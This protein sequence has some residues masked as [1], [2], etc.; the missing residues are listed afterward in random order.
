[1][2]DTLRLQI[3][4]YNCRGFNQTKTAYITSLLASSA[5]L[6]LQ[7]HWLSN[8]QLRLLGDIDDNFIY[9]GVSG[10]DNSDILPG[11]PYGGCAI[12]WKSDLDA[13]VD[14]LQTNSKRLC[15][16]RMIGDTFRLLFINCYMPYENE[17]DPSTTDDFVE[18]LCIIDDLVNSNCDCHI[19]V[20]GDLNVDLSRDRTH[21]LLLNSFCENLELRAVLG[22][23]RCTIDYSYNFNAERFSVLDHFLLSN[24]IFENFVEGACV[25]HDM[26]NTSDHDPIFIKL[27]LNVKFA[28]FNERNRSSRISWPKATESHI[29]DY[30]RALSRKLLDISL[31]VDALACHDLHCSQA[32]H[33]NALQ[34]Y[35]QSITNAC[36]TA[37]A[38]TI[39]RTCTRPNTGRIPGWSEHVR[40]LRER[41][42]F[43]HRMWLDCGRPR[44]GVVSESMR[45]TRA[46]Y[47]Y[48]LRRIRK[49]EEDIVR[50]RTADAMLLN[51]S[52]D[53]WLE[54]KRIR[55]NKACISR[56]IDG[57]TEDH[58][59]VRM[60]A[61]KYR[62]LFSRVPC[63]AEEMRAVENRVS[64]LLDEACF[65][66]NCVVT[67]E[68]V[69][70][71]V[72]RLKTHK[73][74][75]GSELMS[76]HI[77]NAG[78]DL[79][80][81]IACLL[82]T[83]I[84]HG[85]APTTF[86]IGTLVSIP[87]G[88][89]PNTSKSENFRGIA[90]SSILGKVFDN[91][92]LYR[93]QNQLASCDLQFGFKRHSSTNLCTMVLKETLSY[94][95][96]NQTPVFCTFLDASK[97]FDRIHYGK[98]FD[99]L[100][101]RN[102]P[103]CIIRVLIN[104]YTYNLL[105]VRWNGVNTDYFSAVNGVKQGAVL[106][107]VLFC[108][109]LDNLLIALSKAGVGC[110]IGTTFVGALAYADDIVIIA[111]TAT[112]MRKLLAICDGYAREYYMSFNAQKSKFMLL[113]PSR[114]RTLLA[115]YDRCVF[116]INNTPIERVHS[117]SH[118]GHVITSSLCDDDDIAKQRC[119]FIGQAN[120]CFCYFRKLNSSVQYNLFRTY[121]S[122]LYGCELWLLDNHHVEDICIAWRKGLRKIWNVSP[123]THSEL[124]SLI[125]NCL[126][127]LD[128]ICRRSLLFVY[129]CIT[130][131]SPLVGFIAQH[132]I[133]HARGHSFLGRNVSFCMQ[134]YKIPLCH[135]VDGSFVASIY[136][137]VQES[138]D[139]STVA[140]ANLLAEVL[141]LRDGSLILPHGQSSLT[142]DDI[143]D[144]I[145]YICIE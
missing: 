70:S 28:G 1:M 51:N 69:A 9:A 46:A 42:M 137:F 17:N 110:F 133:L 7:E 99:V 98:L 73:S 72:S 8:D 132:G 55:G 130:H 104:L 126:P 78:C 121:C 83:I 76:D 143:N 111:P 19:I 109:Y 49:D 77:I 61:A 88:R 103:V 6:F 2:D 138:Y 13:R 145:E 134:R 116:E 37:A 66:Q 74:E 125:S 82:T 52:R 59:I 60:F 75:G 5:V 11:R 23:D 14:I 3:A 20:G 131:A 101:K 144:I 108:V 136:S 10:F 25:V 118:L 68:E 45:R 129:K 112:A 89:N 64:A 105:R 24:N 117:F 47:H 127:L 141:K 140:S 40:P 93:Y 123:R 128:E 27:L 79:A 65:D 16:I 32:A 30:R 33:L 135:I 86:S 58:N 31:P 97:A 67:V 115:C 36:I 114:Q 124:I 95:V 12:L 63:S 120:N 90:L 107:P 139:E 21:T 106:S 94:Y 35:T 92:I 22:H 81:H 142:R 54:V 71:A 56:T 57:Q 34:E 96:N 53:F 44:T 80:V 113:M 122:N 4:S 119:E 43:W 18:Q 26:D 29:C 48:A 38:N 15:A 41:S 50:E 100:I 62:D 85:V 87:K 84:V 91:I 39:P 102:L